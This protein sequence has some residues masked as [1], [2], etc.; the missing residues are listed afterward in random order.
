MQVILGTL[1]IK[2]FVFFDYLI[3]IFLS[4]L[5]SNYKKKKVIDKVLIDHDQCPT[6]EDLIF[7]ILTLKM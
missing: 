3:I 4:F 1:E 5:I 7:T 6:A 2:D